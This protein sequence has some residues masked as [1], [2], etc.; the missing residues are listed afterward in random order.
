[1]AGPMIDVVVDKGQM[2][3]LTHLMRAVPNGLQRV[4]PP[5]INRTATQARTRASRRIREDLK[6]PVGQ[7]RKRII[8]KRATRARWAASLTLSN[9]RI[10]TVHL[11]ARKATKG[12]YY[13]VAGGKKLL[14]HAFIAKV[15]YVTK[16]ADGGW[17]MGE[18]KQVFVRASFGGVRV[19]RYPIVK[20]WAASLARVYE[21]APGLAAGIMKESGDLL[22]KNIDRRVKYLLEKAG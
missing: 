18:S 10:P 6:V 8:I 15:M 13:N 20:Q 22:H 16:K 14:R 2:A 1:M 21:K 5:A 9:K 3:R 7:I 19:G 17:D 12:I 11:G 4:I